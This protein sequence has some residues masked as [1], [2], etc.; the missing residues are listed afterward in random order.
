[1]REIR[2]A[3]VAAQQNPAAWSSRRG[4]GTEPFSEQKIR[5]R[6]EKGCGA[7][8]DRHSRIF[9]LLVCAVTLTKNPPTDAPGTSARRLSN[10]QPCCSKASRRFRLSET[11]EILLTVRRGMSLCSGG[12][13]DSPDGIYLICA[14]AAAAGAGIE[15]ASAQGAR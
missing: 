5:S 15:T 11:R 7:D 9:N 6:R 8:L 14:C 10:L 4:F 1:M 12:A 13:H 3:K 2:A